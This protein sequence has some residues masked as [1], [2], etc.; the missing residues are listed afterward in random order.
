MSAAS[1]PWEASTTYGNPAPFIQFYAAAG[2]TVTGEVRL[3]A[4]GSAFSFYS[5]DLYSSTTPVPYTITGLRNA[6]PVFTLMD[7]LPNTFGNFRTVA[8]PN[9]AAPID[10]LSIVL[11]NAAATCCRNPMGLDTIVLRR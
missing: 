2:T 7:T 1:G 5:V 9:A 4:G 10:T 8:N 3:T 11:T 6:S